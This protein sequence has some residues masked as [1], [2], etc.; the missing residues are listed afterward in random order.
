M[1]LKELQA[2]WNEFGETDPLYAILTVQ[3]KEHNNWDVDE[4]F[5]SGKKEIEELASYVRSLGAEMT[6]R[7][8][9]DFGCGVGRLTQALAGYYD[10]VCGVDIAQTMVERAR[11]FN[12]HSERC[13]YFVN[14]T[15]DLRMFPDQDF[16]LI[17]SNITLQHM[18]PQ[19]SKGYIREFVRL[20]SPSG[21]LVFQLPSAA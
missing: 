19:H 3:G 16:D 5:A 2:N 12:S 15:G 9:L 18:A 8:A 14:E 6:G 13:K 20:L 1:N 17:Y 7:R 21:L 10:D 4:F 11:G